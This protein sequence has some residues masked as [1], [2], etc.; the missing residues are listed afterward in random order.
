MNVFLFKP[1]PQGHKRQRPE[2][3]EQPDGIGSGERQRWGGWGHAFH[4]PLWV[5]GSDEG[6]G[7]S[8]KRQW[9][10][11]EAD[12]TTLTDAVVVVAVIYT[13]YVCIIYIYAY[14]IYIYEYYK[15]S[16]I[17]FCEDCNF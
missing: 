12:E 5:W 10:G 3:P 8:A 13:F 16:V 7:T 2:C 1:W 11:L 17:I 6:C 14:I 4:G 9:A 15:H